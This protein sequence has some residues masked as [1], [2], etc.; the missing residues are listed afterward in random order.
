[1]TARHGNLARAIHHNQPR[2]F[3]K[4]QKRTA[5]LFA[6][7]FLVSAIAIPSASIQNATA[8]QTQQVDQLFSLFQ[9]PSDMT[10]ALGSA[11]SGAAGGGMLGDIFS[12]MFSQILNFSQNQ[13]AGLTNVFVFHG[14]AS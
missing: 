7:L 9:N 12:L 5:I 14:N 10:G 8:I 13:V 2:C 1:M 4:M 6:S 3:S 11:L